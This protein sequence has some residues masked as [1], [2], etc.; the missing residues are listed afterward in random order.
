M[1]ERLRSYSAIVTAIFL[2]AVLFSSCT[3]AGADLQGDA[4]A[5]SVTEAAA[6]KMRSGFK[7]SPQEFS[8]VKAAYDKYPAAEQLSDVYRQAL[9]QREDWAAL[10]KFL[11]STKRVK[12]EKDRLL[13]GKV[14]LKLG[15]YSEAEKVLSEID[16]PPDTERALLL[17]DALFHT[18]KLEKAAELLDEFWPQIVKQKN[19]EGLILRGLIHFYEGENG[20]AIE[21]LNS[22]L[23]IDPDSIPAHNALSRIYAK[24]GDEAQAAE[25]SKAVERS[26]KKLTENEVRKGRMVDQFYKLQEAYKAGRHSDVIT[27]ANRLISTADPRNKAALYQYL[28]R[29]Y[30]ALGKKAE[31]ADALQK[32]R[33]FSQK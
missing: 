29:S 25:H 15:K 16:S 5:K 13:L 24:T 14:Y 18:G 21:V 4:T 28:Y 7:L 26:Y 12:S 31:A 8:A 17:A 9:I 2:T 6:R 27:Q 30:L 22:V 3:S 10:E 33:Q 11:I 19:K 20:K 1:F 23:E 32:A